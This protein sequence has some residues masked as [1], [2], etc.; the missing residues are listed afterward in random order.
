[1]KRDR[2]ALIPKDRYCQECG[3]RMPENAK[4]CLECGSKLAELGN[5]LDDKPKR[6]YTVQTALKE[7]FQGTIGETKLRSAIRQGQIPHVRVGVKI[8]LRE[9]ALDKWMAAQENA[10]RI[11]S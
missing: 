10:K 11:S 3:T 7:Y 5:F 1:M 6:I 8:L 4:F 2:I 9:E